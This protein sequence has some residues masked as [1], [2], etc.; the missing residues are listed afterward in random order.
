MEK[1]I[2]DFIMKRLGREDEET[3]LS[4]RRIFSISPDIE[5]PWEKIFWTEPMSPDY[6]GSSDLMQSAKDFERGWRAAVSFYLALKDFDRK[7]K[8]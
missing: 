4:L 8:S 2:E 3:R 1:F 5:E 7:D 6:E